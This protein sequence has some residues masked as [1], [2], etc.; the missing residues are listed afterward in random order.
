MFSG[1]SRFKLL[2]RLGTGGMGVVYEALDQQRKIRVAL[3][4]LR[5]TDADLLYRL[6]REFRSL[7]DLVHPNLIGLDELFEEDGHWFFTMELLDGVDLRGYLHRVAR[8]PDATGEDAT[9]GEASAGGWGVSG[10]LPTAPAGEISSTAIVPPV[11]LSLPPPP[12]PGGPAPSDR[13]VEFDQVRQV[14]GQ[15]TEGLLAIH[16]AGKIHRDIKPSNI[17]VTREGRAVILDFGLVTEQ[18]DALRSGEGK[19]VGSVMYMAPEQA[20]AR[21]VGPEADWYSMGVMLYEVVAGRRPFDGAIG[22]VLAAKQYAE[23]PDPRTFNPSCPDELADLCKALL[24]IDPGRRPSGLEV[25]SRLGIRRRPDAAAVLSGPITL[26]QKRLFVGRQAELR[27]LRRAFDD[28]NEARAGGAITAFVHGESGIGKSTLIHHF[29]TAVEAEHARTVVLSGQCREHEAVPFKAMDGVI[30]ALARYVCGLPDVAAAELVPHNAAL[31]PGV[32]PVLGRIPAIAKAPGPTHAASDPFQQRKRVFAALREML[33]LLTERYRLIWVIDDMQWADSDSLRLLGDLLRPPDQPRLLLLASVRSA[34]E[35]PALPR[36]PGEVRRIRL[37]RLGPEESVELAGMLLD[38]LAPEQRI[39]TARIV[40]E[41]AGHPLFIGELVRYAAADSRAAITQLRLD[42]AIWA[43]VSQLHAAPLGVLKILAV[44]V[45]PLSEDLIHAA[46]RLPAGELQKS[47]A[48]LRASNLIRSSLAT[49]ELIEVYHDRVRQAVA[50][51][52]GDGERVELDERI[53]IALESSGAL[54]QPDLLI[55]HLEGARQFDKAAR[56][57]LEAAERAQAGLAFEQA[58]A[59]YEAALRLT[60]WSEAETRDILIKLGGVLAS[61][62]RGPDAARAYRK[63]AEGAEPVTQLTCRIEVADQL[64]Q[65]GLLETGATAMFQ[66]FQENGHHLPGSQLTMALGI[67]WHRIRLALRGLRWTDR[68]KDEIVPRDLALLA[69]YK[70]AS[71]GFILVEPV[72]ASYFVIRGLNL[73]MQLGDRDFI[74]YFLWLESGFRGSEG[75]NK[76]TAFL[77]RA[78]ALMRGHADPRFQTFYRLYQGASAYLAID[79]RF[80]EAVEILDKSDDALAQTANAAWEL[81]AG[82]F[83]LIYSL[84]KIGDFA[85]LRTYAERFIREAEQRGNVY[86]RTTINRLCNILCLVHDNPARARDELETDSWISYSQGYH[87]QHW[88]ELNARVELA[89]YEGSAIDEEFLAQHLLGLKRSFL[90]R[91][92]GFRCDTAWLVGRLALSEAISNRS[93]LRVVRRSIARLVSYRTHYPRMLAT[94]LRATLAVHEDDP[95]LAARQF[96]EVVAIGEASNIAFITEAARR[97]LGALIGGDEGRALIAT[98][99]RWMAQAG[100][101]NF[102]RMTNL[103]SPCKLGAGTA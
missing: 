75:A 5:E 97:R 64:V 28:V 85:R 3:K 92:L 68:R 84:H 67:V 4:T 91:V 98:A 40:D 42:E 80:K 103:A 20:A 16:G 62:G 6:K 32:F 78:D 25:L 54:V 29:V 63:A 99:E 81:S 36:L 101:K 44:A 88:L 31:L 73:A 93:Q 48:L 89:I 52:L 66:L 43:R 90:G 39:Q 96:R 76:H 56:K 58:I 60:A 102:D 50:H 35:D 55:H 11:P 7:R 1:N 45:A 87:S 24:K 9:G 65:S 30:D 69:L 94:M 100:I 46:A 95:A 47:L 34:E 57:A 19:I 15:V 10:H 22:V 37:S 59:L 41:T 49:H 21:A 12:P 26:P 17:I 72:R 14:F 77:A 74:M 53:A 2:R 18:W 27:E 83:F 13:A 61:A 33:C 23:P 82:R 70:A 38:R 71:R 86:T 79:R 8:A 51:H